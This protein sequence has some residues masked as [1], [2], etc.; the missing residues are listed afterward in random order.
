MRDESEEKVKKRYE[1]QKPALD[2]DSAGEYNI[3]KC[4]KPCKRFISNI[5]MM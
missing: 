4:R 5:T 1:R 3:Y 2:F